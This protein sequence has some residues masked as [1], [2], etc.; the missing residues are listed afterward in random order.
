MPAKSAQALRPNAQVMTL[1]DTHAH[2]YDER[3]SSDRD[4]MFSRAAEAGVKRFYLPNVDRATIDGLLELIERYPGQCYPM[5]GVHPCHVKEDFEEE[6]AIAEK[7][8]FQPPE[9]IRFCA[10]G[11]IGLDYYWDKTHI[12]Q[13]KEAYLRQLEWS[14]RL[15]LPV[16][17]HSRDALEDTIGLIEQLNDDRLKGV[18]HCFNGDAGQ[19]ERIVALG[20]HLGIGGVATYKNGGLD[21]VLP[22]VD[23][24]FLL[25]ETDSPYL[26]P[27]PFRGK[28]NEPAYLVHI[29]EVLARWYGT[30]PEAMAK[31]T[32]DNANKL[33][34]FEERAS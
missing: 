20:F 17:I 34:G 6:L 11:E 1:V 25:L 24:S 32:T 10:V 4:A 7:W 21:H 18:F 23:P 33:F 30:T 31:M 29:V 26:A 22:G 3:F 16:A 9:A 19:A 14:V 5:M 28:R 15:G 27:V 13:Q 2:L 12:K 8:L